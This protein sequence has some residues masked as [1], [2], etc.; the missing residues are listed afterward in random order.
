MGLFQVKA[1]V[2]L[3]VES[4]FL[5]YFVKF[6]ECTSSGK[7]SQSGTILYVSNRGKLLKE[8][9][10]PI[11]IF[12]FSD[13]LL[14]NVTQCASH[15]SLPQLSNTRSRFLPKNFFLLWNNLKHSGACGAH[16]VSPHPHNCAMN[17]CCFFSTHRH[18]I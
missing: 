15:C 14:Y 4:L 10:I 17:E 7:F 1:C 11:F 18:L 16:S 8:T 2:S 9:S 5:T 3:K 6:C 12:P 13:S